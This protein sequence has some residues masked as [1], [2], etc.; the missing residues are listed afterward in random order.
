[1]YA[2]LL[3]ALHFTAK[4][5]ECVQKAITAFWLTKNTINMLVGNK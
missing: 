3:T 1:M 5:A 2:V 4:Q